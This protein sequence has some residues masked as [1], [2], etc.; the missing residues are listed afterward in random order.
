MKKSLALIGSLLISGPP[1][2]YA[3]H[4]T[5]PAGD[6]FFLRIAATAGR[7]PM[8]PIPTEDNPL[9]G[10]AR[11]KQL[12]RAGKLPDVFV[13]GRCTYDLGGDPATVWYHRTCK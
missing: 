8:G 12:R 5:F 3:M 9:V 6:A 7:G 4:P 1:S 13:R 11:I 2:A 10:E